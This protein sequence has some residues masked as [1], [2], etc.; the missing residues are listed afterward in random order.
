MRNVVLY[1]LLSLDGVAEHPDE[2]ITDFDD[3]MGEN[4]G[5]VISS[6]DAVLL[7]RRTYDDWAAFWPNS[8]IEPFATF[9]NAVQKF[10]VTSTPPERP[11]TGTSVAGSDLTRFVADLKHQPGADIGVH[12]SISLSQALFQASL[13]DELRLVIAPAVHT[14]GR[15]LF[16]HVNPKRLTLTRSIMSP[17]GYLLVDFQV[18]N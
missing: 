11:W 3:V 14:H 4:L 17:T 6:Q 7:G 18:R 10:V 8:E 16:D 13:V 1:E 15:K 12:G 2:F 9:I 5:R